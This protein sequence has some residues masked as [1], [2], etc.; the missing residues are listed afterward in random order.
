MASSP[1]RSGR[2]AAAGALPYAVVDL[3]TNTFHL[4]VGRFGPDA[5][6]A[7]TVAHR[8]RHYVRVAAEGIDVIGP[9]AYARALAAATSIGEALARHEVAGAAA[10]GTAAFRTAANGPQLRAEVAARL[11]VPVQVIDGRTEAALI[12]AGVQAAGLPPVGR[13]LVVDIGGGSTEFILVED[14]VPGFRDS[15]PLGA[16]VLRRR[17]HREEPFGKT[18]HD[19]LVAHLD[20]ALAELLRH[21]RAPLTLVG[22][23]GTFDVLGDLYGVRL[24][25]ALQEVDPARIRALYRES[26]AM[27]AER[28]LADP[29]IPPERADMIVVALALVDFVLE[30]LPDT[31]VLTCAYA[32]KEG[33]LWCGLELPGGEGGDRGQR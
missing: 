28:R 10:F 24:G 15:Y 32:L 14:G 13:Q 16:Q 27:T 20:V 3:G 22:A 25:P 12:T 21:A 29:R 26:A 18:Q 33:A 2:P 31:R 23:S 5:A 11:G 17:F 6:G 8:E 30:R 19:A 9:A 7:L 1:S 4:L